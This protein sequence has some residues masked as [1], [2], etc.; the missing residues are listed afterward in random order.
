MLMMLLTLIIGASIFA[1]VLK[2]IFKLLGLIFK[3]VGGAILLPFL[4]IGGILFLPFLIIGLGI[5]LIIKLLPLV[6][7]G[8]IIY[9]LYQKFFGEGE[10]WYN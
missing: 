4:I 3:I 7:F 9:F 2:V 5:S 10:Y 6:L 8:E 1:F